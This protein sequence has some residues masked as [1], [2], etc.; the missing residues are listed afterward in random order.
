MSTMTTGPPGYERT[1]STRRRVARRALAVLVSIA[2][3][4]GA[5]LAAYWYLMKPDVSSTSLRCVAP[6]GAASSGTVARTSTKAAAIAP[7]KV[8]V[9]VYNTTTQAGLAGRTATEL[10]RRGFKVDKV[11]ADPKDKE[12]AGVAELRYGPKGSAQATTLNAHVGASKSAR[13]K[14]KDSSVDLVLGASYK[15]MRSPDQAGAVLQPTT[16]RPPGC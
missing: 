3:L 1:V 5:G 2:L 8:T 15:Q 9:N 10:R 11:G 14:R 12:I 16:A 4:V 13:D 6:S 7:E